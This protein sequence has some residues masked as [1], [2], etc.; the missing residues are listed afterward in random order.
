MKA[1]TFSGS[2]ACACVRVPYV[3]FIQSMLRTCVAILWPF[4]I[5]SKGHQSKSRNPEH[6]TKLCTNQG[7]R[8]RDTMTPV[9]IHGRRPLSCIPQAPN[10]WA[11]QRGKLHPGHLSI[12]LCPFLRSDHAN[13]V[14]SAPQQVGKSIYLLLSQRTSHRSQSQRSLA[15]TVPVIAHRI[16]FSPGCNGQDSKTVQQNIAAK[17]LNLDRWPGIV[18]AKPTCKLS[19]LSTTKLSLFQSPSH[20]IY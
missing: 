1:P 8:T 4:D 19:A 6:K 12:L 7:W 3:R 15:S 16:P 17:L 10:R 14:N 18:F 9:V 11:A 5:T 2:S 13:F 20:F